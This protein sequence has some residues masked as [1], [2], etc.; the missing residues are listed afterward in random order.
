MMIINS[1]LSMSP[2]SRI[3]VNTLLP[4]AIACMLF[5]VILGWHASDIITPGLFCWGLLLAY[6][7]A[8]IPSVLHAKFM[9]FFYRRGPL[10]GDAVSLAMSSLSGLAWGVLIPLL[11]GS[12]HSELSETVFATSGGVGML[13]GFFTGMLV[14]M[15]SPRSEN[16]PNKAPEP[17]TT[18][19]TSPA[20]QE[21]RQ[22]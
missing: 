2:N 5:T 13:T 6:L 18:S 21:P 14:M 10:P 12:Q 16:R 1:G 15:A 22:P 7:V 3:A 17:T 4:P 20:A 9:E 19:V 8:G 11:I